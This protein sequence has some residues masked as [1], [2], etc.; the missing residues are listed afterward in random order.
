MSK[1]YFLID[2]RTTEIVIVSQIQELLH[3]GSV[4]L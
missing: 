2:Y 3:F 1:T 4:E